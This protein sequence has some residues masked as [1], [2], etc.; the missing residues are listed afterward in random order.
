MVTIGLHS[1]I[2]LNS[3]KSCQYFVIFG[4]VMKKQTVPNIDIGT[5]SPGIEYF[6]LVKLHFHPRTISP[7]FR[8]NKTT[9]GPGYKLPHRKLMPKPN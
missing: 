1:V 3:K 5:T 7:I 9:F 6:Y 2:E 4:V 8:E